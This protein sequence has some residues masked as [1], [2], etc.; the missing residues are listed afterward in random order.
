MFKRKK[1]KEKERKKSFLK[2]ITNAIFIDEEEYE[3]KKVI[4]SKKKF[5]MFEMVIVAFIF[6]MFGIVSGCLV[7]M[8][9]DTVIGTK[10]DKKIMEFL[11][12]YN[13]IKEDYY[14][15]IN[16]D[17]LID[18]AISG[19]INSLGD[20]HSIYMDVD[21]TND[22]NNSVEGKYV[23]VGITIKYENDVTTIID[24]FKNSPADKDGLKVGDIIT[25]VNGIDTIG[26][27]SS[28]IASIISGD[29]GKVINMVVLRDNENVNVTTSLQEI[30]LESVSI[31]IKEEDNKKIGYIQIS[32]FASNTYKQFNTKLKELEKENIDSLI[33]DV[34]GNTGGHLSVVSDILDLFFQKGTVLYQ[35]QDKKSTVKYS[36]KKS[37]KRDYP[38]VVLT[39]HGSASA[40]EILASCFKERYSDATIVGTTTYGKGTVQKT[41]NLSDGSSYKF[42]TQ[43]WLTS[44]GK[45]IN[46]K[47]VTPDVEVELGEDLGVDEQL[48][49]AINILKEK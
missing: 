42:T 18:A 23:G 31:E 48:D 40:S 8:Y 29:V 41:G 49:A 14:D 5:T 39:N 1:K 6:L 4:D 47:G 3:Q 12:T 32:N 7:T 17:G 13:T 11:E 36:A 9:T 20:E 21:S 35:I 43:K 16:E 45:W 34:R 30:E 25:E 38:V 27:D 10:L 28:E 37:E 33:I 44:K 26:K 46:E 24:I 22:F 15:D 2:K 19:M